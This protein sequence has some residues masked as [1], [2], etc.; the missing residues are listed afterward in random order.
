MEKALLEQQ[1]LSNAKAEAEK[2]AKDKEQ[3]IQDEKD[4]KLAL[5]AAEK[6]AAADELEKRKEAKALALQKE[7]D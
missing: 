3:A 2:A 4:R 1:D 6:K 5:I 7:A